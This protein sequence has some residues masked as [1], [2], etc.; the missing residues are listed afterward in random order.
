MKINKELIEKVAKIARLN[1]NEEEKE[2]LITDFKNILDIFDKIKTVDTNN[3]D[4]SVQPI[5]AENVFRED[6]V[7]DSL[8]LKEVFSHTDHKEKELF[9][10]PRILWYLMKLKNLKN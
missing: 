5:K 9:K 4:L 10:G 6:N 2:C 3:I 7:K 1:L 8:N